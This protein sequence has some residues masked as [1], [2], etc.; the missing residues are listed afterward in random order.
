ML[1]LCEPSRESE[2]YLFLGYECHA[3]R[4]CRHGICLE[5]GL[6]GRLLGAVQAVFLPEEVQLQTV[7]DA[8][9]V[10]D[11]AQVLKPASCKAKA[12]F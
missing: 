5:T 7:G 3:S 4:Y 9:L 10:V 2:D 12:F 1:K 8:E 6:S 11:A